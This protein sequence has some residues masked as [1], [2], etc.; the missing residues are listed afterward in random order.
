M[1]PEK[2]NIKN[3]FKKFMMF[4]IYWNSNGDSKLVPRS[5]FSIGFSVR[6]G[7]T[8]KPREKPGK[9]VAETL[10]EK[11]ASLTAH[12]NVPACP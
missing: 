9:E 12:Q 6:E 5:S 8:Q 4:Y 2:M 3:S 1:L 7:E 11:I 10:D